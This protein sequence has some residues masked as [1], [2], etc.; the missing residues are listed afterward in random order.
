MTGWYA[1]YH[2]DGIEVRRQCLLGH[3]G[4]QQGAPR[5]AQGDPGQP[6]HTTLY[7]TLF[8]FHHIRLGNHF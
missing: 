3:C 6:G 8:L 4:A 1:G 7:R 2:K 5:G